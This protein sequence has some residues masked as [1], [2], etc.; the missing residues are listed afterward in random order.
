MF[1]FYWS[2]IYDVYF[3]FEIRNAKMKEHDNK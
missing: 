3:H 1:M 2:R